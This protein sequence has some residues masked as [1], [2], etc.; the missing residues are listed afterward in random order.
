MTSHAIYPGLDPHNPATLSYGIITEWLRERLGFRGLIITDDLEMGAIKKDPG[1]AEGAVRAFEA[2]N[3]ILLI[4][5]DQR[6]V[7]ESMNR[8]RNRLLSNEALLSRLHESV[9]RIMA[10]KEKFLGGWKPASIKKAERYFKR[11]V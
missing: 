11:N 8:V 2:G 7:R 6:L 5:E 10:A 4:C 9:G 3:D 1:V